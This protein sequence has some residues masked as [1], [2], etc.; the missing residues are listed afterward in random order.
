MLT[1][2]EHEVAIVR[3]PVTALLTGSKSAARK[4]H[5]SLIYRSQPTWVVFG[6]RSNV[7]LHAKGPLQTGLRAQG[8]YCRRRHHGVGD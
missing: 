2:A 6:V 3:D 1:C 7:F 5:L 8:M 4:L